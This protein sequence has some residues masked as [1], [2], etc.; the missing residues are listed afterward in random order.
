MDNSRVIG[1]LVLTRATKRD[2]LVRLCANR[3]LFGQPT[4]DVARDCVKWRVV[5]AGR[6]IMLSLER[7]ETF[8]DFFRDQLLVALGQCGEKRS[9]GVVCHVR[10]D[11]RLKASR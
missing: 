6:E 3:E 11:L 10:H 9:P 2:L 8:E 1:L 7:G 5:R 4:C